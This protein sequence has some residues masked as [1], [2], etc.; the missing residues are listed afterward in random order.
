MATATLGG[1]AGAALLLVTP[2]AVF[3]GLVPWLL[4][5]ATA[6]FAAGPWLMRLLA[7]RGVGRAGRAVSAA[8]I[9]AVS[10]YG[11]YFNG[12]LGILLLATFG[13]LGYEN[14]HGMNGLKSALSVL[15][16]AVSAATFAA[17]G[18]VHWHEAAVMALAATVGGSLGAWMARRIRRTDLLRAGI[19]AVGAAMSAA[20]FAA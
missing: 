8:A 14:L 7:R 18:L 20:F 13:L 9:L 5:A 1:A 2:G 3:D 11:G 4:L 12:G 16:S 17:A 19:V 10:I 6:L 15:L